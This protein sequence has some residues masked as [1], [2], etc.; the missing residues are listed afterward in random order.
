MDFLNSFRVTASGLAAQRLRLNLIAENVA[1]AQT[2]R[3]PEGGPYKRRDPHFMARP[4]DVMMDK[5]TAAGSTGVAVDRVVV[6]NNPPRMQYDPTHPD[7]NADGYVAM[8]NIDVMT[9]MVNMM[10]ASRSYEANVSVLNATKAM[11][12]KAL[13]IGQ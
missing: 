5:E 12:V 2:T 4:F 13:E 7:A 10:S 8:P 6:D 9:E 3:T 11:A 1:N